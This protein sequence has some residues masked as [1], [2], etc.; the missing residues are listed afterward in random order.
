MRY[1]LTTA[2]PYV[3]AS[4]HLGF[5]LEIVQTDAYARFLKSEGNE[6]YFLTGTDENSLK[7]VISAQE[8]NISP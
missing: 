5:V 1:Y 7:N 6:V 8:K 3:N 4:P 2:I